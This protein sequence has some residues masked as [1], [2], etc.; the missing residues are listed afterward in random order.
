M[1]QMEA[2]A[3]E[4]QPLLSEVRGSDMLK[5]VEAIAKGLA[6][7]SSDLRYCWKALRPKNIFFTQ[8]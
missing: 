8:L 7:A 6:D 1:E 4:I 2:L 5:D 3:D